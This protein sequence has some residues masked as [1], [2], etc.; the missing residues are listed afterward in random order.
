MTI[1]KTV[2]KHAASIVLQA[3]PRKKRQGGQYDRPTRVLLLVIVTSRF[4]MVWDASTERRLFLWAK[5]RQH[6]LHGFRRYS[7]SGPTLCGMYAGRTGQLQ[8]NLLPG[9]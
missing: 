6:Q 8:G 9:T 5:S 7:Q 2:E 1:A 3:L 4:A